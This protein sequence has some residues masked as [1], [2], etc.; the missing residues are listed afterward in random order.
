MR[1]QYF[2]LAL[3]AFLLT[4]CSAA[5]PEPLPT[6]TPVP[7]NTPVLPTVTPLTQRVPLLRV[8]ILGETTTTNV[9]ALFDET[10]ADYWNAATQAD[11]WPR[12]YH[13]APPSL[14]PSTRSGQRF[15]PATAKG[16]PSPLVCDSDTCTATV[17]LQPDLTWTDGSPFT[18]E[19]VAF[20]VNTAIQFRL[21]LNWQA[22]YN[23][24]VLDH[25]KALDASTVKFYFKVKPTV[26]D[27]HYG[28]LQG[29]IVNQA[30]WQP[31]IVNAVSLLP[32]ETLQPTIQEL[33]AE[34]AAMQAEV[35]KLNLSLNTMAPGSTVYQET[36]RQTAHLLE[37]LNGVYNKLEKNRAEYETKL[38]E[39]RASLLSRANANEPTLGP[40]KFASR[41]EDRFE[42]QANLGTPFGD[43]WFDS[44]RYV[45]YPDEAAAV[46]ALL[47]DDVDLILTPDGLSTESVKRLENNP[48]ISL[49]RNVTRSAR[50]LAF[51]HANPFLAE[52]ALH[53]ALACMLDPQVLIEKLEGGAAPLSGFVLDDFW[54]NEE[55]SLPCA[56]AMGESRLLEAVR[57]LQEAGYSWS[58]EPDANV[59]GMGLTD[60]NGNVLPRFTLLTPQQDRMREIAAAYIAQQAETLG[61]TLD[62]RASNSDDLL[63]AVYGSRNYDMALLG[64][65]LGA[66]PAYLCEWFMPWDR[67]PFAYS[68]SRPVLPAPVPQA[69]VSG[70]E[71]LVSACEAWAQ[72]SELEVARSH[73]LEAQS[74]LEQGLP[75]IPLYTG[76]RVDAYRN[77]Y[78]PFVKVV[79]GLGGLY[80]APLLAI[81]I[82]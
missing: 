44:L 68:G 24:D 54:A 31:R 67:N 30:Y 46:D 66:Y 47:N 12:L 18:A 39:A 35:D 64:W 55:I 74:A 40:W 10:G 58:R 34:L 14:D 48:E 61:L 70:G 17:T 19:D 20:T 5:T 16:E 43:P 49:S 15:Q 41:I 51:N 78:Y 69:Q 53:Q 23:P 71:G 38:A 37:D 76:T 6:H 42:N 9:W 73:A 50:F 52:P 1:P 80:G 62:V 28:V 32:D 22:A 59:T 13:L 2:L 36:T 77:I 60:P 33:E 26:A 63:Y 8:A 45:T 79:D 65:R 4:A 25:A 57:L 29:P 3:A 56:G 21:G 75:L 81:P 72:A 27:W 7:E 11:Y 82:P